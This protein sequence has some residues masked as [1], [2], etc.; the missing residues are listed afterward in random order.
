MSFSSRYGYV[1]PKLVQLESIDDDLTNCI[2]NVLTA[3]IWIRYMNF[4]RGRDYVSN[5]NMEYPVRLIWESFYKLP[6]DRIPRLWSDCLNTIRNQFFGYEWHLKLDF[7]EFA[8]SIVPDEP[9]QD[10]ID[11]LNQH[12]EREHSAYRVVDEKFVPISNEMEVG[13]VD[14]AVNVGDEFGQV[15]THIRAALGLLSSRENPDYR[16]SIKESI[17]AVEAI[18]KKIAVVDKST[19]SGALSKLA[20]EQ[21][22]NPIL[23]DAYTKLYG[24]TSADDGVRHALMDEA[25]V[26]QDDARFMLIAC[27]AF[28]NYLTAKY[29]LAAAE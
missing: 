28:T 21:G 5:S 2:W 12:L 23:K 22:L 4:G 3:C 26:T 10:M 18:A 20:K 6:I 8:I 27:S 15:S 13:A 9:R 16:N 7:V 1:A 19:L 11:H 17:S 25:N 14:F 24:Y 29:P